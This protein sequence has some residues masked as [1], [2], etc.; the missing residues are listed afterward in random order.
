[1]ADALVLC[2]RMHQP[3]PLRLPAQLIPPRASAAD[4]ES[5]LFDTRGAE[6]VF[7]DTIAPAYEP[8]LAE[9]RSLAQ[10]GVPISVSVSTGFLELA[11]RWAP[12][13]VH[14]TGLLLREPGAEP[15]CAEPTA[16]LLFSFDIA[17]FME[18]MAE[19]RASLGRR[20]RRPVSTAEVS[21]LCLNHEVY[22]AL[23]RVGF[24]GVLSA[25]VGYALR[26]HHPCRPARWGEGPVVLHR[27]TWLSEELAY[28]LRGGSA[29]PERMADTLAELPGTTALITFDFDDF[30][31]GA[32]GVEHGASV[33]GGL[34]AACERRGICLAAASTAAAG[35]GAGALQEPPP[36][37]TEG[38]GLS[39]EALGRDGWWERLV[40]GRM[41][42][43]Y[44]ML[45]LVP[46]AKVRAV[47]RWML[48]RTNLELPR[49]AANG[50]ARPPTYWR[51]LW[52][53][54]DHTQE[55]TATQ[56]LALYDNFIGAAGSY[57]GEGGRG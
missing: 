48:Q 13:L 15:I 4:L 14:L 45:R 12:S 55:D 50:A 42:Q 5:C 3:L 27:L 29:E 41:Q 32:R 53:E 38:D 19:A 30:A 36:T 22:H 54:L 56:V 34:A 43:L 9:A 25:G 51:G 8:A 7:R 16:G 46:D 31:F 1:M 17:E 40:F 28:R 35:A 23:Y 21:G 24:A 49:W 39:V 10:R 20:A 57:L 26:G 33:I 18:C 47:G 11:N 2:C 44:Q 52:W 6:Q 37:V